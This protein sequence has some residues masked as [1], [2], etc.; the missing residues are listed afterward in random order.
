MNFKKATAKTQYSW[1]TNLFNEVISV[2]TLIA[3]N[4]KFHPFQKN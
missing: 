1:Y 4:L 2:M 3:E